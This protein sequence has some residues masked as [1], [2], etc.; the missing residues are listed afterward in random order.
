MPTLNRYSDHLYSL[1]RLMAGLLFACHGAQKLFG[2]LG[3]PQMLHV[4]LMLAA[5]IIEFFGGLLIALGVFT[6]IAALIASGEMAVAYFL[7]HAPHGLWP[8][9]NHGELA[10]LFC[11]VFLYIAS[12]GDGTW[13]A[14]RFLKGK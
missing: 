2:A 9:R 10:V 5:G 12:R 1:M 3:G 7:G 8:I 14:R 6:S 13:S 4:P 11:F